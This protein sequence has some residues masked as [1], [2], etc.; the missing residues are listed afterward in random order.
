MELNGSS[1]IF[2][3]AFHPTVDLLA[4]ALIS[5][6]IEVWKLPTAGDEDEGSAA[7]DES[8][9]V[10]SLSYHTGAC[11]AVRYFGDGR[12][13]SISA[14]QSWAIVGEDGRVAHH[15]QRAHS[16]SLNKL[17]LIDE[18][19]FATG[20]DSGVVKLWDARSPKAAVL[21]WDAHTD[22]VSALQFA[23]NSRQLFSV[24]GDATL[25][26]Y[27]IRNAKNFYKS[28]DQESELT[29]LAVLEDRKLVVCGTDEG[30]LLVFKWGLW[31]DCSDRFPT[32]MD[33]VNTLT[34]LRDG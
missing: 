6:G 25:C 31:G 14:D 24:A 27:D 3:A 9:V 20:D 15:A 19:T 8:D 33:S 4:T 2:D 17:E 23:P 10:L 12:L 29:S 5:G 22:F 13:L 11:R 1:Q 28:D 18:F 21:S 34:C 32:Q 26:V 7:D 30:T 16:S